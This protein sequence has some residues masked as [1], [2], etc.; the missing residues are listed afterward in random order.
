MDNK[1]TAAE[2]LAALECRVASATGEGER[3]RAL[4]ELGVACHAAGEL[5]RALN[6]FAAVTRAEPGNVEARARAE[7]IRDVLDFYCKDL[8]NP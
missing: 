2:R 8:L 7:M 1:V 4:F 6:C 3:A 5:S